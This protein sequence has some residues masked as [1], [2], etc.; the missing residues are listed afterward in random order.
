MSK[1]IWDQT[2][3][4]LYE[5]GVRNG[6]LYPRSTTGTYPLGVAWNGLTAVTES[7][8]GAEATAQYA[9]NIKYLS[10]ISD[11]EFGG[12]IEAFTYPTAFAQ[13]DGTAYPQTGVSVGQQARKSFGFSFR[14]RLGNDTNGTDNEPVSRQTEIKETVAQAIIKR[15]GLK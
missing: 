3:E 5:T 13:C 9:D 11:E 2:G 7:P 4:R 10:L 14:T 8:S 12:T 1:I 6:V 15:R